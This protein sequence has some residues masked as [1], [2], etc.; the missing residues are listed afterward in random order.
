MR[1]HYKGLFTCALLAIVGGSPA[2]SYAEELTVDQQ[3]QMVRSLTEAQRQATMAAN[4]ALTEAQGAKF[5]PLYLEYRGE[6]ARLND[7]TVAMVKELAE[8][9]T[10]LTEARAAALTDESLDLDKRR[11]AL[12]AKYI[13]KYSN[14]LSAVQTGRVL[15]VENKLDALVMIGLAKTIPLVPLS[16]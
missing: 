14:V 2:L 13:A 9:F 5:W 7:R 11:V 6:V 16:M 15:Q 8:N 1:V 4:L 10:I 12:K 3:V